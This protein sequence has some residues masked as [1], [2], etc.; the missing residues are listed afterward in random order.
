MSKKM[1]DKN[2]EQNEYIYGSEP[3]AFIKEKAYLLKSRSRV[4]CF[5][6]GEGRNAV[7]LAE[8]GHDV[9]AYDQSEVGLNK[10]RDLAGETGVSIET[11]TSDL[12]HAVPPKEIYDAAVMVFGHVPR[13]SQKF[14]VDNMLQSLKPGGLLLMEVYSEAQLQYNTG[15]PPSRELLYDPEQVL[16]WLRP[17]F[18]PYF[19]CGE[20]D[21]VEGTKHTGVGH[22]IQ[23][24]VKKKLVK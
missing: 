16:H 17:H 13:E 2:F 9:T 18:C 4:A 19:Y 6:E 3:N 10:A 21:R 11:V 15:G 7:F 23:V 8:L 5:A 14:L 24:V 22:V 12:T 1:W 20:A